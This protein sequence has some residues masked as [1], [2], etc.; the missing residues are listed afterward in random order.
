MKTVRYTLLL[1]LITAFSTCRD[2]DKHGNPL[3][4]T[5]SGEITISVDESLKPLIETSLETYHALYKNARIQPEYLSEN[6]AIQRFLNDSLRLVI[7]T[8]PLNSQELTPFTSKKL[9][10]RATK[11]A[12]DAVA[13]IVHP[14]NK[15]SEL[16][17]EKVKQIFTGEIKTWNQL[18]PAMGNDTIRIVFDHSGA[19]TLNY[20]Q[21][22]FN[23]KAD[24]WPKNFY[25]L[26]A[27]PEVIKYVESHPAALGIIG[28]SWIS[29]TQDSV[30]MQFLSKIKVLALSPPDSA[31]QADMP[32]YQPHQAWI[33]SRYYPFIR[34]VYINSREM[35][36]GLGTGFASFMAGTKGQMMV[37]RSGLVPAQAQ[38]RLVEVKKKMN[39]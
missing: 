28:T 16:A 33:A 12:Y 19:G 5:T 34:E 23:L 21:S 35:W 17:L 4:T 8:R 3:D 15:E 1:I 36:A 27:N 38:V 24:A 26:N 29:D 18:N 25:A 6:Q 30:S 2:T 20:I 32:F 13:L 10:F 11:I 31:I 7:T 22:Y 39:Y 37:L 14:E 9:P